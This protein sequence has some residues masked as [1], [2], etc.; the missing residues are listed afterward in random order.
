MLQCFTGQFSGCSLVFLFCFAADYQRVVA[1]RRVV[2]CAADGRDCELAFTP[3]DA[4]ASKFG[5]REPGGI[6]AFKFLHVALP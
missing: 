2:S 5:V 3:D 1:L 4:P 6:M